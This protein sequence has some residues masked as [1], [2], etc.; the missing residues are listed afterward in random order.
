MTKKELLKTLIR[1]F[2]LRDIP[3]LKPRLLDIPLHLN[4]V[5]TLTGV[6]RS[7]KS[8]ILLQAIEQLR[9]TVPRE[10]IVYLN[11][12]DERLDLATH[13][14]DL[15]VQAYRELY[16]ALDLAQCYFFFDEIQNIPRWELFVRRLDDSVSRHLFITGSNSKLLGSEIAT[17]LRGR[18]LRY[19]V[20]PLSFGEYLAFQGILPDLHSSQSVA[21]INVA[22][23]QFMLHGGFPEVV[24]LDDDNIRRKLLTEY[25][26]VM[27]YRDLIERYQERNVQALKFFLR[28]CIEGVT[29]PLS[30]NKIHNELKSAGF[31]VSKDT[32][33][34]YL[35]QANAI[36]LLQ[37]A[38]KYDPSLVRRELGDKKAYIVDNGLI[39]A[40]SW[41][42][43]QDKG[44]LLENLMAMELRKQGLELLFVKG[45]QE[46][47]FV[48]Q[49]P[50]GE[51]LPMQVCYELGDPTTR[52]REVAGLLAACRF[53]GVQQG[54]IVTRDEDAQWQEDD[55]VTIKV[56]AAWRYLL[57]A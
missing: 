32:L 8:S 4:K 56:V 2:H 24:L 52:A 40:F 7:G 29:S 43:G 12:E 22:F 23:E 38:Y 14:L 49:Q 28:R 20:F 34:Q 37:L 21:L 35:E 41:R 36:Y 46:C 54:V 1:D 55:G 31:R 9:Q 48:V 33:H 47:D 10:Q 44:K 15:I 18:T 42:A 57:C 51:L 19:E 6:R 17:A 3:A 26:D 25:F 13:E 53:C 27:I 5:V 30:I 45:A 16:P 50:T 11:F 39:N